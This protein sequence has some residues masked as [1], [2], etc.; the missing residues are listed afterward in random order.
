MNEEAR[1]HRVYTVM[2]NL[3]IAFAITVAGGPNPTK[4]ASDP[5]W[6]QKALSSYMD[7]SVPSTISLEYEGVVYSCEYT[8]SHIRLGDNYIE[9]KYND[10][11]ARTFFRIN[12]RG[13]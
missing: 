7:P 13:V 4:Y 10:P 9:D 11:E 12:R 1:P 2:R 5:F 3:G 8:G 6:T